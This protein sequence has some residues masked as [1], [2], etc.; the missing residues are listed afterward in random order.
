MSDDPTCGSLFSGVGMLDYG[1][2]LAGW[3]HRW[4]CEV[5]EWRRAVLRKRFPGVPVFDDIRALRGPFAADTERDAVREQPVSVDGRGGAPVA[6]RVGEAAAGVVTLLAGGFPCKGAST[7][8]RRTGL[9]HAETA[10]WG[11]MRRVIREVRPRY[12]LVENVAN[13]LGMAAAPGEPPGSLWG[14]VVGDLA[15]LG[16]CDIRWD[17]VPAAA[18]GAPH[19]RDRV[20]AVARY[21]DG[22]GLEG[23]GV[24]GATAD[25]HQGPD[26]AAISAGADGERDGGQRRESN[27]RAD[28]ARGGDGAAA[29]ADESRAD[30]HTAPGGSRGAASER[31]LGVGVEWGD[32]LPAIR[33]WEAIHGPAPEPLVRRLDDGDAKLRRLRARVDRSRLSALGDGVHVYVGWIV[34]AYV[35][36]LERAR[37]AD[38]PEAA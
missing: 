14:T 27:G 25:R 5:D 7:A 9:E 8:G 10:L 32:Y 19:L 15:A 33:R 20:F 2:H 21:T 23:R 18:V 17:C 4:L 28:A 16:F 29:D 35:M 3:E 13:I 37:L 24:R 38:L 34:G 30:A 26:A 11:E 6:G 22:E 36:Q 31:A 12:V 1:L